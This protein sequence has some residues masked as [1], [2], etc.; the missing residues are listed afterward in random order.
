MENTTFWEECAAQANQDRRRQSRLTFAVPIQV[1]GINS[2]GELFCEETETTNVS[3]SG[4]QFNL[5][6][7]EVT[8]GSVVAIRILPRSSLCSPHSRT[9]FF[10]VQWCRREGNGRFTVGAM[11]LNQEGIWDLVFPNAEQQAS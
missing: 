4:C 2:L 10:R 3:Q 1:A 9:G 6:H 11:Q 8:P 5:G 7:S